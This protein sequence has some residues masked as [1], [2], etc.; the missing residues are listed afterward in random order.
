VLASKASSLESMSEDHFVSAVAIRPGSSMCEGA[1]RS[2]GAQRRT[3]ATAGQ[4][5]IRSMGMRIGALRIRGKP[6]PASVALGN[7]QMP[8]QGV[9]VREN[10]VRRCLG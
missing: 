2:C 6:K 9:K 10:S 7:A 3:A 8:P 1:A 5:S 4:M